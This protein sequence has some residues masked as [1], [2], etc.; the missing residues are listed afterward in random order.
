[1]KTIRSFTDLEIF[2]DSYNNSIDV[3]KNIVNYLPQEEKFD[4]A[5]QLRRS[6]KA[7]PR[8]IVEGYAKKHMPKHFKKYLTDALGENNETI[9]SLQ[10]CLDLY[11]EFIDQKRC[12]DLIISYDILG[13]K[14]YNLAKK[15]ENFT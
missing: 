2:Q 10:H 14:I 3:I 12:Q 1:M 7:I 5:S 8:L 6:S 15:W 4:L 11:N 13:R 9:V